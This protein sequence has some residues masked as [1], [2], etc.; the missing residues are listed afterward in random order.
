VKIEDIRRGFGHLDGDKKHD[1]ERSQAAGGWWACDASGRAKETVPT[2]ETWG[3][4]FVRTTG[5]S[6]RKESKNGSLRRRLTG[7]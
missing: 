6:M 3:K 2:G 4:R 7:G 5:V 1:G